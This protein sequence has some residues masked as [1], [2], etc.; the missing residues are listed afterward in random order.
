MIFCR[1]KLYAVF[2]GVGALGLAAPGPVGA[3]NWPQWRG[4]F[5]NGATTETNL[6]VAWSATNNVAWVAPLPGP[7]AATPAIWGD[8][9]FVS[10]TDAEH[11]LLLLC[12]DRRSGQRR[13][14]QPLGTGDFSKGNNNLAS[15]SPATDGR[16]VYALFGSGDL[17][18]LDP[19]GRVLWARNLGRKFGRFAIMWLYGSS[20]LLWN[21]RLYV[22][23]LQRQPPS[24]AHAADD[25]PARESYL[26][27]LDPQTGKDLWR[28]VRATDAQDESMESYATP[29]PRRGPDGDEILVVGGDCVTAHRADTGAELWRCYGLNPKRDP[30]RRVVPSAVTSGDLV[31]A[32]GPKHEPLMAIR[33]GGRGLV[34]DSHTVWT[35]T[36]STPDVCTPL[37][38]QGRLFVLDGDR[39]HMACLDPQTG[40]VQWEGTLPVEGIIRASPTGADGK[41]YC[42]SE[43]GTVVV[44]SAG[45]TFKILSTVNMDGE[46]PCRASVAVAGGQLFIRTA[47]NLYCIG[48]HSARAA[49]AE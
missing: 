26:L 30:W 8:D 7:S 11:R 42:L 10:S 44:L 48:R 5:F 22:Q 15:P 6:P 34:T 23:V 46:G 25:R 2:A 9:V 40:A 45:D 43:G 20:P 38:Y 28:H 18:A 21:G 39:K 32:C 33:A 14:Q 3:E 31:F 4:P 19:A 49:R 13:W 47:R 24:Y 41:V 29:I 36:A 1:W 35:S 37:V 12:F 27:C 16:A 17:A